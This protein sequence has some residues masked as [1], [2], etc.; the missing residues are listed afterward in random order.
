MNI[1]VNQTLRPVKLFF[2]I[3]PNRKASYVRALKICSSLWGG[4]HFPIIPFYQKFSRNFLTEYHLVGMSPIEFYKNIIDNFD[5]D[6]IVRDEGLDAEWIISIKPDRKIVNIEEIEQSIL[7]NETKFGISILEVLQTIQE[8]E[9][10]HDRTDLLNICCPRISEQNIWA[11]TVCGS[12]SKEYHE[13]LKKIGFADKYISFPSVNNH[14]LEDYTSNETINYL[15]ISAY[16]LNTFGNPIWSGGT[17]IYI[18]QTGHLNDLLNIWNYRALGWKILP[19]PHTQINNKIYR[20]KIEEL[21]RDF[22]A[23]PPLVNKI[24][25]MVSHTLQDEYITELMQTLSSIQVDLDNHVTYIHQ[26]WFPRFWEKRNTLSYDCTAAIEIRSKS[27]HSVLASS[28][29]RIQLPVLSPLFKAKYVRH[30]EP[31]YINELKIDF[32][33]TEGRLA[34]VIPNLPTREIEFI[35]KGSGFDQWIFSEGRMHFMAR[36][37]SD[38]L[39]FTIPRAY[40]VFSKWF[41]NYKLNI[42]HSSSGKLGNQLLKNIGGVYGTNFLVDQGIPPVLSLFENGKTVLKKTL[43]GELSRQR[44]NFREFNRSGIIAKLLDKR[45]IEFGSEVQ[46]SFCDQRSFYQV[47]DFKD[48]LKCPVCQNEFYIPGHNA[49]EIKWAYR[50]M[51]PFSRNNK[52]DGLLC[53]LLTLRFFRISMHPGLITPLLSFEILEDNKVINE[54][55]LAVFYSNGNGRHQPDLFLTECKTEIE[56]KDAD[57]NKMKALGM[58][59]PGTV[60][61]FATLKKDFSDEE[62]KKLRKVVNYFRKG[63]AGR[64]VCPVLLLTGN[65]L[66][67]EERFDPLAKLKPLITGHLR[68]SDEIGHLSD[69][70]CQHYLGLPSFSSIV[71]EKVTQKIKNIKAKEKEKQ[72]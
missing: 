35:I 5:P 19:I 53:V 31:R 61:T 47:A 59:F 55:D 42:R 44:N 14:N 21:Q 68:F 54:V 6:F 57:I 29:L 63:M 28:D 38:Y 23:H 56:F 18:L 1:N 34:Q 69:I 2:L 67:P 27:K 65:E 12:V 72:L 10:K 36:S 52:A 41:G 26:W 58:K 32:D 66:L 33:E 9:F 24:K 45:I 4:K 25:V 50:G 48:Q 60:L 46:C 71:E 43:D 11:M 30:I 15:G 39:S 7:S 51:G 70:T 40:E 17:A 64:P 8:I 3:H 16:D 37:D 22:H 62:K 13:L 49:D 20:S